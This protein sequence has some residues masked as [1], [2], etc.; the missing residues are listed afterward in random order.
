MASIIMVIM[1]L[2]ATLI[3]QQSAA[4]YFDFFA[5]YWFSVSGTQSVSFPH[6]AGSQSEYSPACQTPQEAQIDHAWE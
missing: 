4:D 2:T 1:Y 5:Q 6:S 3:T